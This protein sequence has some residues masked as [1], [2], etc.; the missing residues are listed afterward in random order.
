MYI[1]LGLYNYLSYLNLLN[2]LDFYNIIIK[3]QDLRIEKVLL[4][5]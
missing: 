5:I 2:K 1:C 4:L 3:K